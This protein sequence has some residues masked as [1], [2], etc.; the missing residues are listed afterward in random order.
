MGCKQEPKWK[1]TFNSAFNCC[2]CK[3]E[4]QELPRFWPVL[5]LREISP[6]SGLNPHGKQGDMHG[7]F[8]LVFMFR[9][10]NDEF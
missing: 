9:G 10:I 1:M 4:Q 5:V 7:T 6:L 2:F 8:L 3:N